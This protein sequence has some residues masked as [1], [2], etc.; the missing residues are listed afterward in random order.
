M[1]LFE[2]VGHEE[3]LRCLSGVDMIALIDFYNVASN[4]DAHNR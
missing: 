4:F 1:S 2:E 3:L